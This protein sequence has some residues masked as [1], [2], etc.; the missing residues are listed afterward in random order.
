MEY[1]LKNIDIVGERL[2]DYPVED[3]EFFGGWV[4]FTIGPK[5]IN[6]GDGY[7]IFVC[8]LAWLTKEL[9]W[10]KAIWG[11][12]LLIVERF[13]DKFVVDAIKEALHNLEGEE[14]V[15]E[16]MA[17]YAAWEFESYSDK[18][19]RNYAKNK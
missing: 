17:R 8:T 12:N 18:N 9:E 14:N 15:E 19:L 4:H 5:G 6:E 11:R 16:I 1:E 7:E 2:D 13:E 10:K 3:R